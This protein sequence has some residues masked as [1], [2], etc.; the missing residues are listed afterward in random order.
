MSRR[1]F[2]SFRY[3]DGHKYKEYLDKLFSDSDMIINHSE[4]EDR[5]YLSENTIKNYLYDKLKNTSV[6]IVILTPEAIE[7]KK[8]YTNFGY[9]I[10]DWIYDEIKYSLDDRENNRC[11]GLIA[12]YTPE[13]EKLIIS[14]FANSDLTT[15]N[16]FNNLVRKN[17]FNIKDSYK[18]NPKDGIYDG[19]WDHYCSLIPW[20]KFI[21]N[22]NTYIEYA[23]KKRDNKEQYEIKKRI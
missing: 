20:N 12:V 5:S 11:N 14:K 2:I 15:I 13:A 22:Y 6:T 17:M 3:S 1:V 8:K 9:I 7:H 18:H 4:S 10:D 16:E 23:E 21:N 19:N